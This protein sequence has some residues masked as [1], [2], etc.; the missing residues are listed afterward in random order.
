MQTLTDCDAKI[1]STR[2]ATGQSKGQFKGAL[3]TTSR[4]VQQASTHIFSLIVVH[5]GVDQRCRAIQEKSP[6]L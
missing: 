5:V 2:T 4:T 6:A 1:A 3:D